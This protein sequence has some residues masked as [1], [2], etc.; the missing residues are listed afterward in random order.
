MTNSKSPDFRFSVNY[1]DNKFVFID[2]STRESI[3]GNELVNRIYPNEYSNIPYTNNDHQQDWMSFISL[4]LMSMIS[5]KA[6]YAQNQSTGN[7]VLSLFR[8]SMEFDEAVHHITCYP[9]ASKPSSSKLRGEWLELLEGAY[10][11]IIGRE[12]AT[13][14]PH[15]TI[16][17]FFC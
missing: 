11:H 6:Y 16:W 8:T 14:K 12:L 3:L 7:S 1:K 5:Y 13:E 17:A 10:S 2:K 4:C 9:S 15:G